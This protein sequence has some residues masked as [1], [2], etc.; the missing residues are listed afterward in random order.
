MAIFNKSV[1]PDE[2]KKKSRFSRKKAPK[3]PMYKAQIEPEQKEKKGF[4]IMNRRNMLI[5]TIGIAASMIAGGVFAGDVGVLG[6]LV[7][8]SVFVVV[9]PQVLI[10]YQQFKK[11]K[12][13]E[14]KF[15]NFLRDITESIRSGMPFHRSIIEASKNDYGTL[16]V[17]IKKMASQLSWGVTLDKVLEMFAARIKVSRRLYTSTNIIRESFISGGRVTST[18]ESVADS[19][20]LL[21]ET[22]K[23]KKALLSQYVMLMY[24]ISVIF[25]A[26]IAAINGFLIPIFSPDEQAG[27]AVDE[28]LS[29]GNPCDVCVGF[30]CNVC[31]LYSAVGAV[32]VV[33]PETNQPLPSDDVAIYY[34]SMFFL[35][36][37]MQ[38]IMSGLV[39]GQ[40]AEGSLNAGLKHS[41]I[42]GGITFGSFFILIR[43]G[44]MGI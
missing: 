24:A 11:V 20:T 9:S 10:V 43:L 14:E 40:I 2:G 25:I 36:A 12:D 22:E 44:L 31:D 41:L 27:P 23:E 3:K 26:I 6:I 18:L 42:L 39:A 7:M 19:A 1:K 15:P 35:M 17:E 38:S 21:E 30:E 33:D 13:M 8:I 16:S 34:T 29:L 37:M 5:V 4:D 28:V 32:V